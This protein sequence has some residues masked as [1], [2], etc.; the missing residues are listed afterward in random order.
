MTPRSGSSVPGP[1]MPI[2]GAAIR[3]WTKVTNPNAFSLTL[4]TL[5]GTLFLDESHAADVDFPLGLPL[6]GGGETIVPIDL[7]VSFASMPGLA[8]SIRRA[9][10]RQPL[11]YRLD[12]TVGVDAGQLGPQTF[13]PMTLLRGEIRT[14]S[15]LTGFQSSAGDAGLAIIT[16]M[17]HRSPDA[18]C[19]TLPLMQ[20]GSTVSPDRA[21]AR[22]RYIDAH[23]ADALAL[24]ERVVNIN[25]GTQNFDGV[26]EVGR[27]FRAELDALGFTTRWVDGAPFKRAGHLVAEHPAPGRAS[28]SS[29]IS[30][31]S[32]RKTARSRSS[33]ASTIA[34]PAVPASST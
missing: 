20:S 26:S 4:G 12:G 24:L 7:S 1:A 10:N 13:G 15:R 11:P 33:S 14:A 27:V 18:I 2:G 19:I 29:A 3:L 23:N 6:N 32:S 28:C 5:K 22:R 31:R 8:D 16:R 17:T 21:R 30:T 9:V 34:P 25:S